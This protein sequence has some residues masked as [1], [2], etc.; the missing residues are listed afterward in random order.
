MSA[1]PAI[2]LSSAVSAS[3]PDDRPD[4]GEQ[5]SRK[6]SGQKSG[7][8]PCDPLR[9]RAVMPDRWMAFLHAH[10]SGV[11]HVAFFFGVSDKAARKW[12][13]G[14]GGPQGDKVV[15]AAITNP[16]GFQRYLMEA[17]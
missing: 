7:G 14:T 1:T 12:W 4:A 17:A 16:D 3:W 11:E 8:M 2:S 15:L 13:N 6:W 9:L 10:F 5:S